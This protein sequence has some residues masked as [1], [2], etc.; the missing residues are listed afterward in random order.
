MYESILCENTACPHKGETEAATMIL[1]PR[2][3]AEFASK[4]A[5]L[6]LCNACSMVRSYS[7]FVI[8][9]CFIYNDIHLLQYTNVAF[10]VA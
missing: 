4:S 8:L 2:I 10:P 6:Y 3:A 5:P 9:F 1:D 7:Q